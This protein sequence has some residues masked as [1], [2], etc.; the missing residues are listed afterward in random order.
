VT[1]PTGPGFSLGTAEYVVT[2]GVGT[3][4]VSQVVSI[5]TGSDVS[6]VQCAPCP[7]RSCYSQTD[8]LFDPAMSAT[9]AAF[10]CSSAHCAELGG[11]GNGCLNSQC[12]YMVRYADNSATTGTYGSDDLTLTSSDVVRSFRFGCSHR[13]TGFVGQVDG[14]VGLGGDAESLVQGRRQGGGQGPGPM[15]PEFALNI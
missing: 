13:A 7:A 6:W 2:V 12:Q 3:P 9:Y 10:P 8:K 15:V 4:A 11:E 14:L 5:D 1:I